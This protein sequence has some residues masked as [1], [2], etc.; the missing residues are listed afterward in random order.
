MTEP[1]SKKPLKRDS[2]KAPASADLHARDP[3]DTESFRWN[4]WKADGS[5]EDPTI[6]QKGNRK[7]N[8][9]QEGKPQKIDQRNRK[10]DRTCKRE[11][12]NRSEVT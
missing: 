5:K 6:N 9:A 7:E 2:N 12:Q 8:G 3:G 4:V 1:A 10:G 11:A